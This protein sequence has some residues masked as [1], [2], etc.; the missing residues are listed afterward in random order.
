MW[1]SQEEVKTLIST[2]VSGMNARPEGGG[3]EACLE[4]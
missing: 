1:T 2:A 4:R 3:T